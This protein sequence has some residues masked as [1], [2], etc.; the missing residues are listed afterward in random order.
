MKNK[1]CGLS[2]ERE[3]QLRDLLMNKTGTVSAEDALE[4]AKNRWLK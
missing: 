2:N 3:T 1:I 4:N